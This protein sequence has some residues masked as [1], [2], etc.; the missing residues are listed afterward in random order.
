MLE[1]HAHA[2]HLSAAPLV[3]GGVRMDPF[4]HSAFGS[5]QDCG[6]VAML[7]R[8]VAVSIGTPAS[9]RSE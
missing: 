4:E 5:D 2:D 6:V 3:E 7:D 8:S 9:F 1:T